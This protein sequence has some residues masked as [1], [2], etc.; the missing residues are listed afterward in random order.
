MISAAKGNA[1]DF[2]TGTVGKNFIDEPYVNN[3]PRL[4]NPSLAPA[5]GAEGQ[6]YTYEINYFDADGDEPLDSTVVIDDDGTPL[7]VH[8]MTA[9]DS[10]PT[11]FA[12]GGV[13]TGRKY[14]F[15]LNALAATQTKVHHYYFKFR[16]N[17]N[18]PLIQGKYNISPVRREFGEWSTLPQGDDNGVPTS[19][20]TGPPRY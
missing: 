10:N 20:F 1:V 5:S 2:G 14:R 19:Q 9:V 8:R 11:S 18:S 17:W 6:S 3:R 16:D 13:P 15:V 7:T 4:L 12:P